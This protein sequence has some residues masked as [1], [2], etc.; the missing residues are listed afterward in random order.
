MIK[1]EEAEESA[2]KAAS[3]P[4]LPPPEQTPW[5]KEDA[6]AFYAE[7]REK[8]RNR[9]PWAELLEIRRREW[10]EGRDAY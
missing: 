1:E 3:P 2:R 7:L 10:E 5:S 8:G 9:A 4:P 6:D